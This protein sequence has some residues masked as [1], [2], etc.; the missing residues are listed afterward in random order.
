VMALAVRAREISGI[1][2]SLPLGRL[3]KMILL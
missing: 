3:T 2:F 1:V